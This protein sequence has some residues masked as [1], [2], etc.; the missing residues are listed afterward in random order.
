MS[1]DTGNSSTLFSNTMVDQISQRTT[2]SG[3]IS[4][5]LSDNEDLSASPTLGDA[6]D[7]SES[8]SIVPY[9]LTSVDALLSLSKVFKK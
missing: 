5:T 6:D 9:S 3:T 7:S 1:E 4:P 8:R 2:S